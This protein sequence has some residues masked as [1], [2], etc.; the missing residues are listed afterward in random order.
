MTRHATLLPR[1]SS[2]SGSCQRARD[3]GR[4]AAASYCKGQPLGAP[5]A[6]SL[7]PLSPLTTCSAGKPA[8]MDLSLPTQAEEK[9]RPEVARCSG[10]EG[11]LPPVLGNGSR[12]SRLSSSAAAQ[13]HMTETA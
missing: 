11:F 8:D 2:A 12:L 1:R 7:P 3:A 10:R 13:P 4:Q 6:A 9:K 5:L